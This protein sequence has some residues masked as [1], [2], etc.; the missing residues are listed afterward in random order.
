MQ[1]KIR[2][3]EVEIEVEKLLIVIFI[4]ID[5][6]IICHWKNRDLEKFTKKWRFRE[7]SQNKSIQIKK[8]QD[9]YSRNDL[10]INRYSVLCITNFGLF[11]E[12]SEISLR[13]TQI[14]LI[15][16]AVGTLHDILD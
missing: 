13:V 14:L 10:L 1:E 9:M 3:D 11:S 6:D 2:C 12:C 8:K 16:I 15:C 7:F 4:S 5:N